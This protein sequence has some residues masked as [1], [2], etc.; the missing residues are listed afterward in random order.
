MIWADFFL[1]AIIAISALLSLWRGFVREALSLASWIAALWVAILFFEELG[2]WLGRWIDTPSMRE[3]TGFTILF[4][5][6]V[7]LGGLVNYLAGQL[8]SKTGLTATDRALGILFGVARGVVI[9]AVLVLLAGLTTVPQD[10]WWSESLLLRHFQDMAI[11]L[12]G[13]L[14]PDI[15]QHIH[16]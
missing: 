13:F 9:V 14:P 15:A 12:R 11:W 4:V 5:T 10:P 7:L 1:L 2:D 3:V 8:V 16:Y 6:T